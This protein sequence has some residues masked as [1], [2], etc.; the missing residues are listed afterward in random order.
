MLERRFK[1]RPAGTPSLVE[2]RATDARGEGPVGTESPS[3]GRMHMRLGR[4]LPLGGLLGAIAGALV[5]ALVGLLFF[6]RS[7]AILMSIVG[8][9][10]FGLGVG[11][12]IAGYSSLESPD[13]GDEPSD[14]A[15]PI[16]DRPEAVREEHPDPPDSPTQGFGN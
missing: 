7:A 15:R 11:M 16:A 5:G 13:P 8:A 10:V 4:R 14:T 12:L 3:Q 1:S 2:K 9:G 6:D